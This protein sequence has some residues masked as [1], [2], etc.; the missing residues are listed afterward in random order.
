M[1]GRQQR[2][3]EMFFYIFTAPK[4][5]TSGTFRHA[6]QGVQLGPVVVTRLNLH[7]VL[8]QQLLGPERH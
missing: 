8:P 7:L 2:M 3:N 5:V 1:N 6:G 4:K